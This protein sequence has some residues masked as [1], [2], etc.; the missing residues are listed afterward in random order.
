M[1]DSFQSPPLGGTTYYTDP[2]PAHGA[3]LRGSDARRTS[4]VP[5]RGAKNS[6]EVQRTPVPS[7]KAGASARVA[8]ARLRAGGGLVRE[9]LDGGVRDRAARD[10]A[11]GRIL[12]GGRKLAREV[13]CGRDR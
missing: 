9:R 1:F 8:E 5:P 4:F 13:P 3:P 10:A 12:R 11:V 2:C 7:V 6:R